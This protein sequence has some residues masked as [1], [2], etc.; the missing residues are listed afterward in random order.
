[1]KRI[2]QQVG[3]YVPITIA[4]DPHGN[5]AVN[6]WKP[7]RDPQLPGDLRTPTPAIQSGRWLI[8]SAI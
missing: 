6:M 5:L 3:A 4:C 8:G 2:R 1:M 7:H